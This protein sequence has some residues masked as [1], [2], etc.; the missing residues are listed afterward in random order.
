MDSLYGCDATPFSGE[1]MFMAG[2]I[3][4]LCRIPL[5]PWV[6]QGPV[7]LS[8]QWGP[9]AV[10]CRPGHRNA[11]TGRGHPQPPPIPSAAVMGEARE[12]PLFAATTAHGLLYL[13]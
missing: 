6:V 11:K 4:Q 5:R 2:H 9:Q 8:R 3:G 12:A 7:E 1:A 10:P 13:T